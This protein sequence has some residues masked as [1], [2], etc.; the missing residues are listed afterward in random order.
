MVLIF[1]VIYASFQDFKNL[2]LGKH[3]LIEP[4]AH[5]CGHEARR[6]PLASHQKK[7][8][9]FDAYDISDLFCAPFIRHGRFP[10]SCAEVPFD[11]LNFFQSE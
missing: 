10:A 5:T 3:P 6:N 9:A 11:F 4:R 7:A 2:A 8:L 1:R